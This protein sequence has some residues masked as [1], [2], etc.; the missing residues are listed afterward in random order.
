MSESAER[1]EWGSFL[2][3]AK[4]PSPALLIQEFCR[5]KPDRTLQVYRDE[6]V[7]RVALF[8]L[9]NSYHND[10]NPL[11]KQSEVRR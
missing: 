11:E 8:Y 10:E 3:S 9:A 7:R 6:V 5:V 1:L 4:S 2:V